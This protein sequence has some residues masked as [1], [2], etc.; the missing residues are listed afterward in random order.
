MG[1]QPSEPSV[2]RIRRKEGR[3][4][5]H[6]RCGRGSAL[7]C[8]VGGDVE[9]IGLLALEVGVI[10][11][12]LFAEL[13][14]RRHGGLQ[15]LLPPHH[16]PLQRFYPQLGL[17][18]QL[19]RAELRIP[20]VGCEKTSGAR[21]YVS[22]ARVPERALGSWR[23]ARLLAPDRL[24]LATRTSTAAGAAHRPSCHPSCHPSC[25]RPS[26]SAACC[27]LSGRRGLA[28]CAERQRA[29][30]TT[31][32]SALVRLQLRQTTHRGETATSLGY[33]PWRRWRP[34]ARSQHPFLRAARPCPRPPAPVTHARSPRVAGGQEARRGF[35]GRRL[36]VPREQLSGGE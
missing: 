13:P 28:P 35:R 5:G 12:H 3:A 15:L 11:V 17:H 6:A 19:R 36:R 2:Q 27:G 18:E 4:G 29:R 7:A 34:A 1:G 9:D 32:L 16:L 25:R 26:S 33:T 31:A 24:S 22:D 20:R 23:Y 10:L 30:A 14:L 8:H 21:A